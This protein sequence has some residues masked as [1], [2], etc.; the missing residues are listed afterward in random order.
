MNCL[1]CLRGKTSEGKKSDENTEDK[2]E[3]EELPVAQPKEN[4]LAKQ[5]SGMYYL[6]KTLYAYNRN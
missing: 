3:D 4:P 6:S 2:I 5:P 1:P